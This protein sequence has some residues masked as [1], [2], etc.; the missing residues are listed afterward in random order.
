MGD[1]T[2]PTTKTSTTVLLAFGIL[3]VLS[4]VSV[5][6]SALAD[7][8]TKTLGDSSDIG[9]LRGTWKLSKCVACCNSTQRFTGGEFEIRPGHYVGG[10]WGFDA[11]YDCDGP[12]GGTTTGTLYSPTGG[13]SGWGKG[14]A[15]MVQVVEVGGGVEIRLSDTRG[16]R[17]VLYRP[18]FVFPYDALLSSVGSGSSAGEADPIWEGPPVLC[19]CDI[20]WPNGELVFDAGKGW[21]GLCVQSSSRARAVDAQIRA[22]FRMI[23]PGQGELGSVECS[24]CVPDSPQQ[25]QPVDSRGFCRSG[26]APAR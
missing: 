23:Y 1:R 16:V 2:N 13:D 4:L 9:V 12:S 21:A 3:L 17:F 19:Y 10:E 11:N 5:I 24:R 6:P 8:R 20:K 7:R 15:H 18:D 22:G 14:W 26:Y 25:A